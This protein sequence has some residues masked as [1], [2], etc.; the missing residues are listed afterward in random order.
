MINIKNIA[1]LVTLGTLLM[2]CNCKKKTADKNAKNETAM[3]AVKV[4]P[5]YVAPAENDPFTIDN[6]VVDGDNLVLYVSYSGGCKTH[7]FE[8][9]AS[10]VYMKSM[11]PKIGVFIA[12]ENNEDLCK[13]VVSDTLTFDL[14]TIKYPGKTSDYTVVVNVNNWKG[15]LVYKY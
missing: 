13:A 8:A 4:Q 9:F 12:H 5:G 11:P 6:A 15:D 7:V 10:D 3:N 1:L 2:S 14:S